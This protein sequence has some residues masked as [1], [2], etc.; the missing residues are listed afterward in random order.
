MLFL[1]LLILGRALC[2]DEIFR[3]SRYIT[4][5]GENCDYDLNEWRTNFPKRSWTPSPV[6]V[7]FSL[8]LLKISWIILCL[9]LHV[10][11]IRSARWW[12]HMTTR[13][14]VV[15]ELHNGAFEEWKIRCRCLY[16]L[17]GPVEFRWNRRVWDYIFSTISRKLF[18]L[19]NTPS[20]E[21]LSNPLW[22]YGYAMSL[23]YLY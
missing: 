15:C 14:C 20:H 5:Q 13:V 9:D 1:Q 7:C 19:E 22:S 10:W 3:I 12:A 6:Y 18:F 21:L 23:R 8:S 2:P 4:N 11:C 17:T 16:N